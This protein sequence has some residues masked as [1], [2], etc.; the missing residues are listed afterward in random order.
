LNVRA[1]VLGHS[2][3]FTGRPS[4]CGSCWVVVGLVL[5]FIKSCSS[6]GAIGRA[7]FAASILQMARDSMWTKRESLGDRAVGKA[8]PRLFQDLNLARC[9][10]PTTS[11]ATSN[12]SC[13]SA[14]FIGTPS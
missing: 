10:T 14:E 3:V 9:Q 1:R 2:V 6:L 7:E 8:L 5:E 13:S 12:D 4:S 11:R